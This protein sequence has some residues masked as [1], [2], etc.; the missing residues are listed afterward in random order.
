MPLL[1]HQ[2]AKPAETITNEV[3]ASLS[4]LPGVDNIEKRQ[5]K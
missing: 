3:A 1:L 4:L 5:S 2:L